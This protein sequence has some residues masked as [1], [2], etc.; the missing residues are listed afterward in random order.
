M[1]MLSMCRRC[2]CCS[3]HIFPMLS[4]QLM[5][6]YTLLSLCIGWSPIPWPFERIQKFESQWIAEGIG[7]Q[8]HCQHLIAVRW[9]EKTTSVCFTGLLHIFFFSLFRLLSLSL[10]LSISYFPLLHHL[11]HPM[12]SFM[13]LLL[14]PSLGRSANVH[15]ESIKKYALYVITTEEN[16]VPGK[17]VY[18]VVVHLYECRS[19]F[20]LLQTVWISVKY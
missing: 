10:S 9:R 11:F 18:L 12:P 4:E 15:S 13:I 14:I 1:K 8:I 3:L 17:V 7:T 19:I 6:C 16:I 20:W 2:S 5:F